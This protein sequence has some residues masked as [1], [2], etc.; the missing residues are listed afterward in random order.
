MRSIPPCANGA[1][2]PIS[3]TEPVFGTA[4]S[5]EVGGL[6]FDVLTAG[7]AEGPPVILLHGFP[8]SAGSW[9]LV[10]PRLVEAGL[11]VVAPNQRGYSAGARPTAVADYATE[12]LVGDVVGLLDALGLESAH[13]VGHDWGAAV[14]WPLAV[15]H[16]ERVRSLTAVS[17]PHLAAYGAALRTDPDQQQRASYIGLLRQPGKAED[18]LLENGAARLRAMYG[19]AVPVDQAEEHLQL[20]SQPGAL[21]AVLNWYRAMTADLANLAPARVPT[22]YVWSDQD[23]AIGRAGASH[24]GDFVDAPFDYV[25]LTGISHWIP[26]EAPERL[27]AAII[28]RIASTD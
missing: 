20:L 22:T 7:S 3:A 16:P 1:A 5:I 26:E 10:A 19:N 24:C 18:L 28:D 9:S 8:Q 15:H 11:R 21:T 2:P 14:A 12:N 23:M 25:E 17:I 4:S 27:S 13:I 6:T